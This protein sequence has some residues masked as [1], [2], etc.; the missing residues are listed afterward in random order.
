MADRE[1]GVNSETFAFRLI[2][3]WIHRANAHWRSWA[4][5][6]YSTITRRTSLFH[7]THRALLW[8]RRTFHQPF[9]IHAARA[10]L[11]S[12]PT[13]LNYHRYVLLFRSLLLLPRIYRNKIYGR[14]RFTTPSI[15][16][17]LCVLRFM[18]IL[19]FGSF[20]LEI[21]IF[22]TFVSFFTLSLDLFLALGY[23]F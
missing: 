23:Y 1:R 10:S 14:T 3:R 21:D 17:S 12:Y 20:Y 22:L 7:R 15:S 16:L 18:D 13:Q 9:V 2:R 19:Y 4:Q 6:E 5:N 8:T 11:F